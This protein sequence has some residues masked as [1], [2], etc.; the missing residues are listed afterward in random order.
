MR[1]WTKDDEL[2]F[3]VAYALRQMRPLLRRIV[4]K[5]YAESMVDCFGKGRE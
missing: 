5:K 1:P 2:R 3:A 4:L